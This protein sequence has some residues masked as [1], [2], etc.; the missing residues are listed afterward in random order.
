MESKMK[1]DDK[2]LVLMDRY[3]Q[4]RGSRGLEAVKYLE[5]AMKLRERGNVSEDA[6]IGAAY[7]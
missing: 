3:K 2:Y 4:L 6:V 5:A 1:D 7:L